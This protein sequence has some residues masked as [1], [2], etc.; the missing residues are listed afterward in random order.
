[1]H[2]ISIKVSNLKK[3]YGPVKAVDGISFK[4]EA[5]IIFGMLGPNG[6]GKSTTIETLVGLIDKNDGDINILGMNPDN[7]LNKIRKNIGVQL[8]SPSLFPRLKVKEIINLFA[9]FYPAPLP[10]EEVISKVGLNEKVNEQVR[11]LSG[12]QKHRLA[13]ALAMVSNGDIIF[14]D[15]PTTGLDPQARHQLWEVILDL[16]KAGVT[17]FLTTHYMEE[18]ERLCDK[19]VIIDRG[20]IIAEGSPQE[21]I[22]SYFKERAI[23]FTDP[24]LSEAEYTQLKEEKIGKRINYEEKG[25]KIIVY[26]DDIIESMVQLFAFGKKMARDIDDI[27]I[28]HATLED[29]FL[30]LTGRVMRE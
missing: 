28:R 15:E 17:V 16:K 20:K 21:L 3:Y 6:A 19:L 10:T 22:D 13:I 4:V 2:K 29:V 1:M 12:G 5:G 23:Q 26:T 8:Q 24:G 11:T 30:K 14:L 7:E 25:N 18:A 9:S 27:V